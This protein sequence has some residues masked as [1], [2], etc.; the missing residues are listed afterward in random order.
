MEGEENGG[1][2]EDL[3]RGRGKFWGR[4]EEEE[5][6]EGTRE[7]IN[8]SGSLVKLGVRHSN[9]PLTPYPFPLDPTAS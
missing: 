3:E 6:K 5:G 7:R 9:L 1:G 2:V 8:Y 4:E